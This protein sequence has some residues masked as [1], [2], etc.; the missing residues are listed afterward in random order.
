MASAVDIAT[1]LLEK[2]PLIARRSRYPGYLAWSLTKWKRIIVFHE[3]VNGIE[4]AAFL[5]AR[6]LPPEAME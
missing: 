1:G 2:R 4:I 6:Q 3:I 5:D